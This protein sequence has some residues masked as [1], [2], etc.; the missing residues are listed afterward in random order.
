M[1]ALLFP[2][3]VVVLLGSTSAFADDQAM[4]H[5]VNSSYTPG[6]IE[7]VLVYVNDRGKV[8]DALPAYRLSPELSRLLRTNLDEMIHKPAYDKQGKPMASQFII[9]VA[10]QSAPRNAGGYDAHFAYVSAS[11]VPPGRWY[12]SHD[13]SGRLGLASSDALASGVTQQFVTP[14]APVY[15]PPSSNRGR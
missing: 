3:L 11:P 1:R 15:P 4:P 2:A 6:N 9:N 13:A 5:V 14:S 10:L 8:T 7:P 12:W